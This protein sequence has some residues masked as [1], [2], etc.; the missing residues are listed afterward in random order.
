[1]RQAIDNARLREALE[2]KL[3]AVNGAVEAVAE[4][5]REL[6]AIAVLGEQFREWIQRALDDKGVC[7]TSSEQ[8]HR[9]IAWRFARFSQK[10]AKGCDFPSSCVSIKFNNF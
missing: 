2:A 5:T 3:A 8:T 6:P 9:K 4:P 1:M 10:L 7:V